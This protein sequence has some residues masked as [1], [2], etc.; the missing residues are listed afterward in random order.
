MDYTDDSCMFEFTLGQAD[1]MDLA[2]QAYRGGSA[3]TSDAECNDG[4]ACNGSETC[5]TGSGECEAGTPI[6]C[7]DG[8]ACTTD[9]CNSA[10]GCTATPVSCNDG[11]ACTADACDAQLGCVATPV[12]DGQPC[13]DGN[14]CN[15]GETCQAGSCSA[16]TPLVCDDGD[17]C[18][19]DSCNPTTGCVF[20]PS[21]STTIAT[22]SFEPNGATGW[23]GAWQLSGDAGIVSNGGP[24]GGSRHLRLRRSSG[25]A[26]R[27]FATN[28]ATAVRLKFWAKPSSFEGNDRALV[29]VTNASN[30]LVTVRT[31][32]AAEGNGVYRFYDL[33]LSGIALGA[34][35]SIVFDA[36]MSQSNDIL[37][38]DDIEVTRTN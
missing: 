33:D 22:E 31:I 37:Y 5:N 25:L 13:A 28:G 11:N 3:C 17:A 8:D 29:R 35:T 20:A 26:R 19:A 18:T 10:T 4:N 23:S 30:T 34:T 9:S 14:V 1:R 12:A 6:V 24:H 38:V 32:T 15:G 2:W 16:G 36:N 7:N 21:C 27:S